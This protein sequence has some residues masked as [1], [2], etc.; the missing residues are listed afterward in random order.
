M[1]SRSPLFFHYRIELHTAVSLLEETSR[2]RHSLEFL[3][4]ALSRQGL[5]DDFY[6]L[7]EHMGGCRAH[8][9]GPEADLQGGHYHSLHA[10]IHVS[11]RLAWRHAPALRAATKLA[12][13]IANDCLRASSPRVLQQLIPGYSSRSVSDSR[14]T[15]FSA[16]IHVAWAAFLRNRPT[17]MYAS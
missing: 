4:R 11:L 14:S 7:R 17:D 15:G 10:H 6:A 12:C 8:N 3:I 9:Q 5:Q 13:A 2:P 1:Y 16:G